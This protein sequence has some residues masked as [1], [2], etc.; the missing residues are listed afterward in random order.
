MIKMISV[1]KGWWFN[2][3]KIFFEI[4]DIENFVFQKKVFRKN[5]FRDFVFQRNVLPSGVFL[6]EKCHIIDLFHGWVDDSIF[7]GLRRIIFVIFR[8]FMKMYYRKMNDSYSRALFLFQV[9]VPSTL[10]FLWLWRNRFELICL[11]SQ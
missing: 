6:L 8:C 2:D 10:A 5:F 3:D 11:Y 7:Y 4:F 1:S 9:F